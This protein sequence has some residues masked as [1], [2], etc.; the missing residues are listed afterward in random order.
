MNIVSYVCREGEDLKF[1]Y[2]D[3]DFDSSKFPSCVK[4]LM[5]GRKGRDCCETII[6]EFGSKAEELFKAKGYLLAPKVLW[7]ETEG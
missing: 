2:V 6:T 5:K 3:G 4:E 7:S 1:L